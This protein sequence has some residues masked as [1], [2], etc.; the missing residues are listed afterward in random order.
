ME[1]NDEGEEEE[2]EEDDDDEAGEVISN[3]GRMLSQC[4]TVHSQ[5]L[6][7]H[8][9]RLHACTPCA[10]LLASA[11]VEC[12]EMPAGINQWPPNAVTQYRG[13]MLPVS[14]ISPCV[15][16]HACNSHNVDHASLICALLPSGRCNSQKGTVRNRH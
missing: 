11:L 7:L 15:T 12:A 16:S 3:P 14:G 2:E 5:I 13:H 1:I 9:W 8:Q 6:F 4:T 10:P